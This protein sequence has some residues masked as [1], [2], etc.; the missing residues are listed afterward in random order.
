[1]HD[2]QA[3]AFRRAGLA[4][5]QELLVEE[6][7]SAPLAEV[8]RQFGVTENDLLARAAQD[9]LFV[10]ADA[11]GCMRCPRWQFAQSGK[12]LPGLG[13]VLRTLRRSPGFSEVTPLLFLLQPHP[14]TS[15]R[16]L[17]ALRAGDLESVLSAAEQ[18]SD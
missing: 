13:Q 9:Q 11:E 8:A 2:E 15:G 14:R 5:R 17:D 16:P 10:I 1:M 12:V 3:D 18:E 4:A 6:G 7:G